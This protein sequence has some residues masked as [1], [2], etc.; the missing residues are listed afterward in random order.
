MAVDEGFA[1]LVG[2]VRV[3]A[4]FVIVAFGEEVFVAMLDDGFGVGLDLFD[5]AEDFGDLDVE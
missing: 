2:G 1:D 5:D 3:F 4:F